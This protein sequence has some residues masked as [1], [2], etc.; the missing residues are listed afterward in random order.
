MEL[1]TMKMKKIY[2]FFLIPALALVSCGKKNPDSPGTEF[3]PDMYRSTS[4]EA[5]SAN[6]YF[7]DGQTNRQPVPGTIS[8][9]NMPYPYAND[10]LGYELAGHWLKNPLAPSPEVIAKGTELYGKFCSHCHGD[11]GQGDGHMVNIGKYPAPPPSYTGALKNL[12]EGKMMHTLQYGK[13]MMGSHAS[14]LNTTERWQIIRYVQTLQGID[15]TK[16]SADSV[17]LQ[18]SGRLIIK[19]KEEKNK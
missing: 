4:Y 11:A 17:Y 13:G 1:A 16:T 3:M 15:F 2:P 8:R 6:P 12:S 7:T 19:K 9:E 10:S 14:Q 18:R 5:N